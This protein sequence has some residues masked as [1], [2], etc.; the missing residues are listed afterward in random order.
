MR[1]AVTLLPQSYPQGLIFGYT[2]CVVSA[3]G[4][5]LTSLLQTFFTDPGQ[6]SPA[7][8]RK[9]K[10]H[11]LDAS[12]VETDLREISDRANRVKFEVSSLNRAVLRQMSVTVHSKVPSSDVEMSNLSETQTDQQLPDICKF[13]FCEKCA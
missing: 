11:I 13:S 10:L 6:V 12:Q 9:V 7:L 5:A 4:L 2:F 1:S 8:I 3:F